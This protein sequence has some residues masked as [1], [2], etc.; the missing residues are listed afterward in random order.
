MPC[1]PEGDVPSKHGMP[2]HPTCHIEV[3]DE[4]DVSKRINRQQLGSR[5]QSEQMIS[6]QSGL[7][8]SAPLLTQASSFLW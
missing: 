8:G 6:E 2:F 5:I 1:V 3:D 4:T 7:N